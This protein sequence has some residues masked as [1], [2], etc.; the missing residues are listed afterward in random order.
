M[1]CST[2]TGA[3]FTQGHQGEN[4]L[5]SWPWSLGGRHRR[6]YL[7]AFPSKGAQQGLWLRAL[8]GSGSDVGRWARDPVEA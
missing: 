8:V 7:T 6:L 5:A 1:Q 2:Q 3:G 4:I